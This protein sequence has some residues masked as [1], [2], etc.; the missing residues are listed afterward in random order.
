MKAL[1]FRVRNYRNIEDSGWVTLDPVTVLVGRNESGKTSLLKALNKFNPGT[2]ETYD[3]QREFPRDRYTRDYVLAGSTGAEWPVCSI[4]FEIPEQQKSDIATLLGP[5]RTVPETVTVTRHYDGH[6]GFSYMPQVGAKPAQPV[7]LMEILEGLALADDSPRLAA[8]SSE[9]YDRFAGLDD[10]TSA[11]GRALLTEI[12]EEISGLDDERLSALGAVVT[13]MLRMPFGSRVID[14]VNALVERELPRLVYFE[15]YGVLDSAIWLP[16][17]FRGLEREEPEP[18]FRTAL[19]LFR[20]AGLDPRDIAELGATGNRASGETMQRQMEERAIRLNA[21][22]VDISRRCAELWSQRRHRIRYHV[23]GDYFRIR[24]ADDSLEDVEIELES[25]GKGFQW[26]LSFFLVFAAESEGGMGD[27]IVLLDEPGLSLHPTAQRELLVFFERLSAQNQVIYTTHSPFLIDGDHLDRVRPVFEDDTGHARILKGSWPAHPETVF[28][29]KAAAGYAMFD[30]L[31][32]Q[33]RSLLV[34]HVSDAC[35]LEALSRH[36]ARTGRSALDGSIEVVPCG[37]AAV[38]GYLASLLMAENRRPLILF[39]GTDTARLRRHGLVTELL[40]EG[41][42]SIVLLDEAL[43]WSGHD[44]CLEDLFGE[45]IILEGLGSA[46]GIRL[47]LGEDGHQ[48]SL[49]GRIESAAVAANIMLPRSWR[50]STALEVTS[51]QAS[52]PDDVLD[53]A[54][55]LFTKLAGDGKGR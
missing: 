24:V 9:W 4:E 26:F 54:S 32:E 3:A 55:L 5:E 44:V 46:T 36:C 50:L 10:V 30:S 47:S 48:A 22:S 31:T 11:T 14:H 20:H 53:S 45:R 35:Y 1:R 40:D 12:D 33:G 15:N 51:S 19:A 8:W 39:D 28:A 41:D 13:A 29:L 17:M 34:E 38:C 42:S 18:R 37:G 2:A 52:L 25:R 21:A 7:P 6:L 16:E 49:V 23:D 43:G 27:A